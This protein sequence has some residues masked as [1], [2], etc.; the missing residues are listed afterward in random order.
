M[1]ASSFYHPVDPQL[2][3]GD[4]LE[5]VPHILLKEQ[6]RPIQKATFPGNRSAYQLAELAEG[7]LPQTPEEG[8]L[9][10]ATCH[11]TR[12]MVLTHDC[13]IDKD[14]R[15][16][17]VLL[18]RPLPANL[19]ESERTTIRENKKYSFFYLPAGDNTLPESYVDFRR[20]CTVSPQWVD[21]AT[22]LASLSPDARQAMLIQLFRF[23]ARVELRQE[24]FRAE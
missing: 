24:I 13:E 4:I 12:A 2:C 18:I 16:R 14:M 6:P 3:Q 9:V 1:D 19:P 22:R 23:L 8:V 20:I 11:V 21:S 17:S 10:P 15:H 7:A 5:R